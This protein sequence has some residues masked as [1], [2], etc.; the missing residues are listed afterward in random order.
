MILKKRLAREIV[1]EFHSSEAAGEA[2]A[3][4]ERV[5]Q[6]K[7]VHANISIG[8]SVSASAVWRR[9]IGKWLVSKGLVKSN[10]EAKRLI[11]QGAIQ[12]IHEDGTK[13]VVSEGY[14]EIKLGDVIQYGKRRWVRIVNA[15]A[16]Q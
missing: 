11:A 10:S 5:V 15:D 13:D 14:V 8:V 16:K 2:Q 12:I 1:T 3:H 9:D 4:F 6:R 7:E